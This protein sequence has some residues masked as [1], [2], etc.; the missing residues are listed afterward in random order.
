MQ[1]SNINEAGK[2]NEQM[3]RIKRK[4]GD[5]DDIIVSGS[6]L[7]YD[8]EEAKQFIHVKYHASAEPVDMKC[9]T[10]TCLITTNHVIPIGGYL[11]HDWEDNNGSQSKNV[12]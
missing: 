8:G 5:L 12:H 2:Q 6:H 11:F 4:T 7:V 9:E 1:I 3:Y 10:L